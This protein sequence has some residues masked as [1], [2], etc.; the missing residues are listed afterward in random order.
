ME[1]SRILNLSLLPP[2]KQLQ[3]C[4][5]GAVSYQDIEDEL[6]ERGVIDL[7]NNKRGALTF[8]PWST[9]PS[10]TIPQPFWRLLLSAEA[11]EVDGLVR[12]INL[13]NEKLDQLRSI[14]PI[15]HSSVGISFRNFSCMKSKP[16]RLQHFIFQLWYTSAATRRNCRTHSPLWRKRAAFV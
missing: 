11:A 4:D 14:L 3:S 7:E 15:Y 13:P 12:P 2:R 9:T 6:N 8:W 5:F 10:L 16:A 1:K